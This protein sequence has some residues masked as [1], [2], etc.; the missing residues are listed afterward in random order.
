MTL[1]RRVLRLMSFSLLAVLAVVVPSQS[2]ARG[3]SLEASYR[4][5]DPNLTAYGI[6]SDNHVPDAYIDRSDP[7]RRTPSITSDSSN[8]QLDLRGSTRTLH[9]DFDKPLSLSALPT[10]APVSGWFAP[11]AN[12]LQ[13]ADYG[14]V[15]DLQPGTTNTFSMVYYWTGMGADGKS[16]D[17]NVAYR[18]RDGSGLVAV[19]NA[20]GNHWSLETIQGVS[21]R[22]SVYLSGKGGGWNVVGDYDMPFHVDLARH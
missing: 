10:L 3:F 21:A 20:D 14:G 17:Y 1:E 8:F 5:A 6:T 22:V 2:A 18:Q 11:Q 19:A 13:T 16:H 7:G 15:F 12:T 4:D 9:L